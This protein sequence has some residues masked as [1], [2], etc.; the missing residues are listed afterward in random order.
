MG[1]EGTVVCAAA[2]RP[3]AMPAQRRR[4]VMASVGR[5]RRGSAACWR[6]YVGGRAPAARSSPADSGRPVRDCRV[7]IRGHGGTKRPGPAPVGTREKPARLGVENSPRAK[8]A[9]G[10]GELIP[11]ARPAPPASARASRMVCRLRLRRRRRR[12]A[13]SKPARRP[14]RKT[15]ELGVCPSGSIAGGPA[16]RPWP[17]GGR[18]RCSSWVVVASRM[19]ACGRRCRSGT[20]PAPR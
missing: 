15:A 4:R 12:T 10:T 1:T 7:A 5:P 13:G 14:G 6:S 17:I 20:A 2:A 9:S 18:S 16:A 3:S 8:G 11:A 19:S